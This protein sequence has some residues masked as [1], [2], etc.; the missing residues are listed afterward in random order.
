MNCPGVSGEQS[1]KRMSRELEGRDPCRR[2]STPRGSQPTSAR[3]V[4]PFKEN[5]SNCSSDSAAY[6]SIMEKPGCSRFTL[7]E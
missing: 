4:R 1:P 6:A 7:R 3:G 2:E 5:R